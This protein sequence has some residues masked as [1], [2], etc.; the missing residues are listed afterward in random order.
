MPER[1]FGVVEGDVG[2]HVVARLPIGRRGHVEAGVVVVRD[3]GVVGRENRLLLNEA[4]AGIER[5]GEPAI[6]AAH[7]QAV[8]HDLHALADAARRRAAQLQRALHVTGAVRVGRRIVEEGVPA[9]APLAGFALVEGTRAAYD[10]VR[11]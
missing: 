4:A 8:E 11:V 3:V 1:A 6:E 9:A 5:V 10:G 7:A 2:A